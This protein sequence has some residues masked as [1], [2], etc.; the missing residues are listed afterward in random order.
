MAEILLSK[1]KVALVDDSNFVEL[2]QWSWRSSAKGYAFR[3]GLKREGILYRKTISMH[4]QIMGVFDPKIE[5]DHHNHN[6]LDNRRHNLR[7]CSRSQN[8]SNSMLDRDSTHGYKGVALLKDKVRNK[9]WQA[10]IKV[11]GKSVSLGYFLTKQQAA[12]AYN[13]AALNYFGEFAHLNE[14]I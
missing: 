12:L 9:P 11:E 14:V 2:N 7:V 8:A 4:R 13:E 3:T 5:V 6:K 1:D 10:R